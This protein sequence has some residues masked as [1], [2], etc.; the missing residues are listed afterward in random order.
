MSTPW[1]TDKWFTSPWNFLPE[2]RSG[3]EFP[4]KIKLH[5]V[6]LRDGEQQAGIIFTKDEKIR[7]A[8]ALAEAGVHRI[9]AG[10]P[11]VSPQDEAAIKEIVK[12]NLPGTEIFAFS[13]CMKEDVKRSV[14]CG[15]KGI[16][17][18]IPSSTHMIEK[19]YGWKLDKAIE[20]SVEATRYAH[21]QGLYVVF[22][23]IDLSRAE[24]NWGLSLLEKVAQEGW[25]DA[26]AVVDT[27]G[28][29][30]PHAVPWLVK[31]VKERIKDKPIECHFHDDFGMGAANTL[32]ALAAG[33]EVAHTTIAALGE[34]A[35]N[36]PYEDLTVALLTMY[37]VDLGIKTE[38]LVPIAKLTEEITGMPN[39]WN[40]GIIGDRLTQIES[41]IISGWYRNCK[42]DPTMLFPI[43][44]ALVGAEPLSVVLGKNAGADSIKVWLDNRG[45]RA[46]DEE[47]QAMVTAVKE[48]AYAK[49]GLLNE[50][51]FHDLLAKVK[52][53]LTSA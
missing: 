44:P 31:K 46:S 40:R 49:H 28:G 47:I 16:V 26:L 19:A 13:R 25:M 1:R 27:L 53:T 22:F 6:T 30:A 51:D 10:M 4:A 45:L 48:R 39:R 17:V 38:R 50:A 8:E 2:V 23:P 15:V 36:A 3:L 14:D 33:A 34:R 7:I 43:D 5:D 18:E 35:G 20:L 9:E 24:L 12:R 41:G 52:S 32:L 21:E 29:L 11:A 42:D 37:G